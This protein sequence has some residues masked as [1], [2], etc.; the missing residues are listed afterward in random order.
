[1]FFPY[2][3]CLSFVLFLD[4]LKVE[5]IILHHW[6]EQLGELKVACSSDA[7]ERWGIPD[8]VD[9]T[10]FASIISRSRK[11]CVSITDGMPATVNYYWS[12]SCSC[13]D[14]KWCASLFLRLLFA[15]VPASTAGCH[16][17]CQWN[18]PCRLSTNLWCYP[19]TALRYAVYAENSLLLSALF[20]ASCWQSRDAVTTNRYLPLPS[21]WGNNC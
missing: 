16:N 3:I 13:L 20:G 17:G 1:M 11:S 6:S 10:T 21:I 18:L 9:P 7:M 15:S 4:N 2:Y 8:L 5:R 14:V 19:G 12:W